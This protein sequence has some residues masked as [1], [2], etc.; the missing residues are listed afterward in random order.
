EDVLYSSIF[1]LTWD[2]P[3]ALRSGPPKS[4][5]LKAKDRMQVE[6]ESRVIA[7][8]FRHASRVLN[9]PLPDVYVQPRRAG[10]LLLA[11]CIE[12]GAR[13]RGEGA[14]PSV[15]SAADRVRSP[16]GAAW[17]RIRCRPAT[18]RPAVTAASPSVSRL[19]GWR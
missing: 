17:S 14:G 13:R 1:A 19:S 15:R 7:K 2:G 12:K 9:A 5:E 10:R 18:S 6:G 4:F 3:V 8:I 11:T 16:R